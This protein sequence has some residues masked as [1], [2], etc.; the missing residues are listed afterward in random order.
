MK[1]P[2][3]EIINSK[4]GK[5][6]VSILLGLGLASLFRVACESRNCLI[7]KAPSLDKIKGKIF[8]HNQKC[9]KYLEKST[10][11]NDLHNNVTLDIDDDSTNKQ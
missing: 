10:S 8:G 4:R 1:I 2:L 6:L 11:C 3:K 5:Y 7:F 9:Y